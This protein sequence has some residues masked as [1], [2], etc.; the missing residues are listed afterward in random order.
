MP[1]LLAEH[2]GCTRAQIEDFPSQ[3]SLKNIQNSFYGRLP[4]Q[5][6]ASLQEIAKAHIESFNWAMEEGLQLAL[7]EIN[8]LEFMIGLFCS[9]YPLCMLSRPVIVS[10]N[11]NSLVR[12]ICN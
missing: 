1:A 10:Q 3:P 9:F 2:P 12:V 5:Q 4:K 7:N 8:P 11:N 6:H